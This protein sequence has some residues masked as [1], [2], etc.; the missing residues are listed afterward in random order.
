MCTTTFA[1]TNNIGA[2]KSFLRCNII[3]RYVHC[4]IWLTFFYHI[5]ALV[6]FINSKGNI[7]DMTLDSEK[8]K[9][10]RIQVKFT[11]DQT[12]IRQDSKPL[13]YFSYLFIYSFNQ[14]PYFPPDL[15]CELNPASGKYE[16]RHFSF[17]VDGEFVGTNQIECLY[18]SKLFRFRV[19]II[20]KWTMNSSAKYFNSI[21]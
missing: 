19:T 10:A 17:W 7:K 21:F 11:F 9:S 18:R 16:F 6:V 20:Y 8:P 13:M 5:V 12:M 14:R 1:R 4:F 15:S 3:V 2:S